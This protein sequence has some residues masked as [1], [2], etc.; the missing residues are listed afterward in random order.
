MNIEPLRIEGS[1]VIT[2][3]QFPDDRGVFMEGF[4]ADKLTD[5]IGHQMQVVQTNISVSSA[6]TVR[7]IHFA[8]VPPSQA[9]YITATSGSLIDYIV[10]LRV[11]SPTFGQWDSVLLDGTDR[12]AV[13]LSEGL[14]HAFCALEGGTTAVYLCSAVYN[15][16]REHGIHPLDPAIGLELPPGSKPVLSPKDAAAP[17]LADA[18]AAGLLPSYDACRQYRQTLRR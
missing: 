6:G 18:E 17:T 4:R 12:K 1:W 15:P 8:D 10:D 5:A 14:G 11:G 9:K 16:E 2:P 7:G 13:Y 3:R